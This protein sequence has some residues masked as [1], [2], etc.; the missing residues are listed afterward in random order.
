M[1]LYQ[2]RELESALKEFGSGD[3]SEKEIFE[4]KMLQLRDMN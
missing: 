2:R 1:E 4:Q 3:Q